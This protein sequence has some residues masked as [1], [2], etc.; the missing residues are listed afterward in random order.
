MVRSLN[1]ILVSLYVP[2]T[3]R[4]PEAPLLTAAAF[5]ISMNRRKRR[6]HRTIIVK[7]FMS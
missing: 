1:Q 6:K 3:V 4:P 2:L 7:G 5:R